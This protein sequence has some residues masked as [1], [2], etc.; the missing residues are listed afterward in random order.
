MDCPTCG[1][2][3]TGTAF[4][5]TCGGA[6]TATPPAPPVATATAPDRPAPSEP[7]PTPPG[8]VKVADDLVLIERRVLP[9]AAVVAAVLV[10]LAIAGSAVWFLLGRAIAGGA[11]SPEE[12]VLAAAEAVSNEDVVGV[13]AMLHPDEAAGV[14]ELYRDIEGHLVESGFLAGDPFAGVDLELTDLELRVTELGPDLARVA[15]RDGSFAVSTDGAALDPAVRRANASGADIDERYELTDEF[16]AYDDLNGREVELDVFVMATKHRGKW[17]LSPSYTGAQYVVELYDLPG[18]DPDAAPVPIDGGPFAESPEAALT[19]LIEGASR[20][21]VDLFTEGFTTRLPFLAAYEDALDELLDLARDATPE[22]RDTDIEVEDIEVTAEALADGRTKVSLDRLELDL[23]YEGESATIELDGDCLRSTGSGS[24]DACLPGTFAEHSGLDG[25]F[26]VMAEEAGGWRLD[27]TATLLEYAR[28]L[29]LTPDVTVL[30]RALDLAHIAPAT[31]TVDE[32]TRP[33]ELSDAGTAVL[34]FEGADAQRWAF[35]VPGDADVRVTDPSGAWLTND[36][37]GCEPC[38]FQL[39]RSGTHRLVIQAEQWESSTLDVSVTH[40]TVTLL[41]LGSH[42]IEVPPGALGIFTIDPDRERFY[43]DADRDVRDG[44]TVVP[45]GERSEDACW[46]TSDPCSGRHIVYVAGGTD[47]VDG[48]FSTHKLRYGF[49]PSYSPSVSGSVASG[50]VDYRAFLPPNTSGRIRL[51]PGPSFDGVLTVSGPGFY[52][53]ADGGFEGDPET[54]F[55]QTGSSADTWTI[56]V[57]GFLGMGGSF[58]LR[59][60][61]PGVS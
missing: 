26:V 5:T 2:A 27:P 3:T 50:S 59:L 51:I 56:N 21:D 41:G 23:S 6:L 19:A 30:A 7:P 38:L 48:T 29:V 55:I 58:T 53:F 46:T 52:D 60:E 36:V 1:V 13:I 32:G 18:P 8:A 11:A 28:Q 57:R 49:A 35:S 40:P 34:E 43:L 17:F 4:C 24:D 33:T 14:A 45:A 54:V 9:R 61:I 39:E 44:M 22:L 31:G 25:F 16:S 47:G 37:P 42:A 20:L 12:A 10:I 15:I